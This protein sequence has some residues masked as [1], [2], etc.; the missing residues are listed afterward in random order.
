MSDFYQCMQ[1]A[2]KASDLPITED[3][4]R[5]LDLYYQLL[6]EWNKKMNLTAITEP[7]EVAVKHIID[8]LS[9]W[10]D[11]LFHQDIAVLDIGTGAGFPGLPLKIMHP[12]IE[13]TL[14]D[15]LQ[16]RVRFL[17]A[18]VEAL[19][20]A[21]VCILHGRAEELAQREEF[22]EQYDIVCSRAVAKLPVLLEYALPFIKNSGYFISLKGR[23]YEEE[24][25]QS[26][27]A[28]KI[29]GGKIEKIK[30]VVLPGLEDKRAVLYVR[31]VKHTAAKY[32]RK[33]GTPERQPL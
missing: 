16:K 24:I 4:L 29:L 25:A 9:A 2:A 12:E 8:S 18:V 10:D 1:E 14:L 19:D 3:Q 30:P 17:I 33:A 13:L 27:R 11:G 15:A 22:R 28:L 6:I 5:K 7:Q 31:K 20:L 26:D 21:N 32:P 23:H